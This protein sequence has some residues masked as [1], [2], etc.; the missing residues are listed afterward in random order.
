MSIP[1]QSQIHS[2]SDSD[3]D[4]LLAL[5]RFQYMTAAQVAR[6]VFPGCVDDN[7][8][9]Q[10]RLKRLTDAGYVLRLRET[11]KP[12]YGSHP[13][14]FTLAIRGRQYLS[15][16]GIDIPTYYRPSEEARKAWNFPFMQH[17]LATVDVL[18]AAQRL[19]KGQTGGEVAVA[20]EAMLTERQLKR[21]STRVHV[22]PAPGQPARLAAEERTEP[23]IPDA[24]F[25]LRVA[26]GLPV[27]I[28]LE[29]D[30]GTEEQ[31]YWRQKVA[32]LTAWAE[33]P[34]R[35]VYETDNLTIA[36]VCPTEG[37]RDQLRGWTGRELARRQLHRLGDIFLF[38]A[39]SPVTTT[40]FDF[41]FA[42]HWFN[43]DEKPPVA[44]LDLPAVQLDHLPVRSF[45]PTDG[46]PPSS[47]VR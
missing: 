6:L 24:W 25:Q 37:R 19:C 39:L 8:Y 44:I 42:A 4:I 23:V 30:R 27:S 41:F 38:T 35:D 34:Y 43:P 13:Y 45:T 18:V 12:Q 7:R 16:C 40:P 10:R 31:K 26:D 28:A 32:A 14:V 36:I 5:G 47:F 3:T 9:S 15:L 29:L 33:G 1:M 17:A 21:R 20:C 11:A 46:L 22:L 2:L